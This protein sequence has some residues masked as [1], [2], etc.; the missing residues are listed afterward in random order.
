MD[1][2]TGTSR[3]GTLGTS[4]DTGARPLAGRVVAVTGA[5]GF[6]GSHIALALLS[7]GADVLAAV[8]TPAKGAWL[9]QRGARLVAADLTDRASLLAAFSGVD[10]VVSNAALGGRQRDLGS[11]ER[12][13]CEGVCDLFDAAHEALVKR[14]VHIS[15]T[16]VYRTRLFLPMAEDALGYD[17]AVRRFNWSDATTDWRYARTKTLSERIAW[18]RA[19]LHGLALTTLRPGPIYG[20]RDVKATA[21]L[22]ASLARRLLAVPT[23]GVPWVHA[24][25][26]AQAVVAALLT[27][28]SH[29]QAY[30]VAGPPVSQYRF[31][32]A[33]RRALAYRGERLAWLLPVPVP[34]WVR[35]DTSLAT[36]DLGFSSRPIEAGLR[37]ACASEA[38]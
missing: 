14:V 2:V 6:L 27:P 17:P 28:R 13:N 18:E 7:A 29:G 30:N 22:R 9:A 11:Y 16:A 10:S 3:D 26:V 33:M 35:Y 8:R 34:V 38:A 25:D 4:R 19:G 15:T 20:S 24:D 12:V 31:M 5:T 1:D 32:Q 23:I 21:R 37:E 36:R